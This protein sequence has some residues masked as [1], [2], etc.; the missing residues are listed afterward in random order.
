[1][2]PIKQGIAVLILL[3]L[4]DIVTTV[5]VLSKG[6]VELNPFAALFMATLGTI[7][8]LIVLKSIIIGLILSSFSQVHVRTVWILN[9]VFIAVVA[10]NT[11]TFYTI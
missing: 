2:T 4:L 3:Q 8:G 5:M 10:W 7:P 9:Y 1:M 11:Y 6:G